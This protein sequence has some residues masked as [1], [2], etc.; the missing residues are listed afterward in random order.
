MTDG[1]KLVQREITT[2]IVMMM[3]Q[4]VPLNA[5]LID[6]SAVRTGETGAETRRRKRTGTGDEQGDPSGIQ[7]GVG[8]IQQREE[9]LTQGGGLL[10]E[11][12][13][14]L[15]QQ[16]ICIALLVILSPGTNSSCIAQSSP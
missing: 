9:D 14:Q 11:T 13:G 4:V 15:V 2:Q 8:G 6:P 1:K 7:E 12:M 16:C 3:V 10:I 5:S